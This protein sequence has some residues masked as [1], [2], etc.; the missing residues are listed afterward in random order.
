MRNSYKIKKIYLQWADRISDPF[1]RSVFRKLKKKSPQNFIIHGG[2]YT[3]QNGN[4]CKFFDAK[5]FKGRL[6]IVE[7]GKKIV[8]G[9]HKTTEE[10]IKFDPNA[11]DFFDAAKIEDII[12]LLDEDPKQLKKYEMTVDE[13]IEKI[14]QDPGG[15]FQP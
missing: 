12:Q 5:S 2:F 15:Y 1:Y 14:P 10:R 11:L 4:R 8:L 3:D 9:R 7:R 13:F 6:V